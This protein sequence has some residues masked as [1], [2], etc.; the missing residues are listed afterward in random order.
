MDF[1]QGITK[2]YA[3]YTGGDDIGGR[4]KP[5]TTSRSIHPRYGTTSFSVRSFVKLEFND[6]VMEHVL[7]RL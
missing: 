1:L 5:K 6:L 2:K 3:Q 4:V 7:L